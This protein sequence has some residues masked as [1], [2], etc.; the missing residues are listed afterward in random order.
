[1]PWKTL[2]IEEL[3]DGYGEPLWYAIDGS[4]RRSTSII[5]SDNRASQL[6]Y[7]QDGTTKI[8]M[9]GSE[10]AAVVFAPGRPLGEQNRG[11][12]AQQ[13]DPANYLD[14]GLGF[15]NAS[16]GGPYIQGIVKNSSGNVL[17]N[18][19]LIVIS[20]GELIS[21]VETRV[22]RT[23]GKMLDAYFAANGGSYPYPARFN[24]PACLD[25]SITSYCNS[26]K[27]ICRGRIPQ[28]ASLTT[29]ALNDWPEDPTSP[30]NPVMPLWF[31][32]NLWG[33]LLY[34][35][36]DSSVLK[37]ASPPVSCAPK[38]SG[39]S[40][41]VV[42][43]FPGSAL[44]LVNRNSGGMESTNLADYFEDPENQDGWSPGGNDNYVSPGTSGVVSNDHILTIK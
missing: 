2:G 44:G 13:K 23:V 10:A 20:S 17:V 36:A 3:V 16:G 40:V 42:V 22:L 39:G 8:T 25:A 28:V 37:P 12:V 11:T 24:D 30:G 31:S 4:F 18:D 5:N 14:S 33:Q 6:V 38:I 43:L 34:Y 15:T 21:A 35:S 1:L 26:D 7:A 27:S 32:A 41:K 9:D 29:P 19:R